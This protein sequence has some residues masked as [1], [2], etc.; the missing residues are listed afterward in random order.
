MFVALICW[1]SPSRPLLSIHRPKL[2]LAKQVWDISYYCW[3]FCLSF[4]IWEMWLGASQLHGSIP[5]LLHERPH[6]TDPSRSSLVIW[7]VKGCNWV[8]QFVTAYSAWCN[9][10]DTKYV[11]SHPFQLVLCSYLGHF[12]FHFLTH[13]DPQSSQVFINR[14]YNSVVMYL[15]HVSE[16]CQVLKLIA[17]NWKLRPVSG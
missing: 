3:Y 16:P 12:Y 10:S 2:Q 7:K 14:T 13:L 8:Q 17:Y 4:L 6:A 9:I 1:H 15:L 11:I 5:W